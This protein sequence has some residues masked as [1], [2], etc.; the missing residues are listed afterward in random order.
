MKR[1]IL[2]SLLC[3]IAHQVSAGDAI[4][5][6]FDCDGVWTAVTY[7]RSSTPKE[8]H[9]Y[10]NATQA[11]GFAVRD[12]RIRTPENLARTKIIGQSDR[13]GY[14]AVARGG[15]ANENKDVTT[16]GRGTS[17]KEADENALM[18]LNERQATENEKIVY[19][20]FSFGADSGARPPKNRVT[21]HPRAGKQKD[22][23]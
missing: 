16:I 4:A 10:W 8:G 3:L 18:K 23:S 19:Q 12:L 5:I 2:T 6:A 13:T 9:H 7:F 1:I 15:V 11:C 21:K 14:V 17:Q 22:P 20:Y